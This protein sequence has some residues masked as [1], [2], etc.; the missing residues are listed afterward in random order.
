MTGAGAGGA[1]GAGTPLGSGISLSG[2][3]STVA[4]A[5]IGRGASG[6]VPARA[7]RSA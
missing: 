2:K 7:E 1:A 6:H 5:M 4:A 3:G